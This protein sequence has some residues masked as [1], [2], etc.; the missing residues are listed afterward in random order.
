M[1]RLASAVSNV[2]WVFRT[3]ALALMIASSG[4]TLSP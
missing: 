3:N 1:I 2:W 4:V